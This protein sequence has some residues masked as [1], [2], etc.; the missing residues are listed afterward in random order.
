LAFRSTE[1]IGHAYGN[2][3]S[4]LAYYLVFS[5]FEFYI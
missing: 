4:H 1:K 5:Q 2:P 3:L